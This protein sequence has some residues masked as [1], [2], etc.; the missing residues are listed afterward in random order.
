ME[1][2]CEV[3]IFTAV[4]TACLC[5]CATI[6]R[7]QACVSPL[8]CTWRSCVGINHN[9]FFKRQWQLRVDVGPLK[10]QRLSESGLKWNNLIYTHMQIYIN[11][12]HR[13]EKERDRGVWQ[14]SVTM[15]LTA[16]SSVLFTQCLWWS[17]HMKESEG[18]FAWSQN[19]EQHHY[20][21]KT[22][23]TCSWSQRIWRVTSP[24]LQQTVYR[25]PKRWECDKRK[26]M[27][28]SL[29][30]SNT[31]TRNKT[32]FYKWFLLLDTALVAAWSIS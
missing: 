9:F 4:G 20:A 2:L 10:C 30:H 8:V 11:I 13:D 16:T 32:Y 28:G 25:Q 29:P 1:V 21:Y 14:I 3:S 24:H 17:T 5:V 12:L 22:T 26:S 15:C 23:V 18:G 6:F 31:N 27:K 19:G 7:V